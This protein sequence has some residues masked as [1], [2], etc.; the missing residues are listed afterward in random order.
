MSGVLPLASH[1]RQLALSAP[2]Q[3]SHDASQAAHVLLDVSY[4]PGP[5]LPRSWHAS[6]TRMGRIQLR[7]HVWQSSGDA[8][9]H[10]LQSK[11]SH[12]LHCGPH[13]LGS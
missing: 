6:P 12:A 8:G 9:W 10:T 4:M 13:A 7:R 2:S 3:L 1:V 11:L 5:Q